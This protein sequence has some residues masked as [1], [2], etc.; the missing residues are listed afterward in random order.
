MDVEDAT[1][2]LEA[3]GLVVGGVDGPPT[4]EVA[5]TDPPAGTE[6]RQGSEVVLSTRPPP[7]DEDDD[8]DGPGGGPGGG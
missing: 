8:E 3:A 7:D 2:E 6:I 4:R 5:A 1:A